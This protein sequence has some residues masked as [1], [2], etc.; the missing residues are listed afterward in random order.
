MTWQRPLV[1]KEMS[2]VNLAHSVKEIYLFMMILDSKVDSF[3]QICLRKDA[4]LVL[5]HAGSWA[6]SKAQ[7][8]FPFQNSNWT[9]KAHI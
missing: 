6:A 8:F 3:L 4:T 7:A 9:F 5:T 1:C 2:G